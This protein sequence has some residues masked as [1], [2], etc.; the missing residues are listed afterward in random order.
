[1]VNV[2]LVTGSS[3]FLGRA[4]AERFVAA[5]HHVIGLDPAKPLASIVRH[6]TDDL[7][8]PVRLRELLA[9]EGITDII[10]AGGVSG[11][12]VM[13]DRPDRVIAINVAGTLN[14]LQ[15]ALDAKT[16]T[17][18]FCSSVSA[19]GEFYEK[20]PIGD[21]HPLQPTNTYGCSKAAVDM[22]LRGL[23]RRLPLDLCSLRFTG[24]YGP[25]RRTQFVVDDIVDSALSGHPVR[26]PAAT[27]WP[28]IYVD[29]AADAVIAAC[30]CAHRRQLSYFIA[31]PEQVSLMDLATAAAEAAGH[32]PV[33][34]EIDQT[35]PP[36]SR[37]PL[38]IAPAQRDFGFSPRIDHREG[39]R[40][41]V[42]AR[43]RI[44]A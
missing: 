34:L 44:S 19:I 41:M 30:F 42:A 31:Y 20:E 23:W 14:L 36:S 40:R 29:D 25:G 35:K 15:A 13:P 3:G 37:G 12:M 22:V 32:H 4:V 7:S 17:F 21:D 11:P 9:G 26:V 5:G 43:T 28:Y 33:R 27:D 38:D 39:I 2:V 8:D 6:V 24:I 10:H 16:K 1:M 18:I